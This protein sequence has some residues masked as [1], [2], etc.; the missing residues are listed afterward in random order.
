MARRLQK[1][2]HESIKVCRSAAADY[3][4]RHTAVAVGDVGGRLGGQHRTLRQ[5]GDHCDMEL[6]LMLFACVGWHG[7]TQL[8]P[9]IQGILGGK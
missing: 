3:H 4:P 5:P 2:G 8:R 7:G 9:S 1:E 6:M